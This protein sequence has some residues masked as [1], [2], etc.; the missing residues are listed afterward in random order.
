MIIN[1]INIGTAVEVPDCNHPQPHIT[2]VNDPELGLPVF[3]FD[4]H[5]ETDN[6]RCINLD[7]LRTEI[8]TYNR[9]PQDL[10]GFEGDSVSF[11]W[12][13]KLGN[14]TE[15]QPS[16]TFTHIY[17]IKAVGGNNNNIFLFLKNETI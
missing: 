7:R 6:D 10:Q 8:K 2:Q 14:D 11:S 4:S 5:V 1:S 15:F 17:Q 9:S 3:K 16:A 13:M 12:D